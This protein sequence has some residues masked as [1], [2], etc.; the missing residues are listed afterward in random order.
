MVTIQAT[1]IGGGSR[2]GEPATFIG[3]GSRTGE[4]ATFIGGG[5]RTGDPATFIGGGSRTGE[6]ATFIGGGSRTGEPATFIGGGSRTGELA[7][8]LLCAGKECVTGAATALIA[9]R[10]TAEP[11]TTHET[12]NHDEV[13][14][15]TPQR[16]Q[17]NMHERL[18][19]IVHFSTTKVLNNQK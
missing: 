19:Q 18:T 1:F 9:D 5:S 4:L 8:S 2:T 11:R 14:W 15:N 17:R 7:A 12:F 6:P 13:I 10:A 3:G 16:V